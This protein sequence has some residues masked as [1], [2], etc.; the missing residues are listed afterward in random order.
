MKDKVKSFIERK[1]KGLTFHSD[2]NGVSAYSCITTEWMMGV[3]VSETQVT[4]AVKNRYTGELTGERTVR[5]L[6]RTS[7]MVLAM[8]NG[9]INNTTRSHDL[10]G[11]VSA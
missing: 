5:Y 8:V 1:F 3:F 4:V 2:K 9:A 11:K 7:V 6:S 10:S